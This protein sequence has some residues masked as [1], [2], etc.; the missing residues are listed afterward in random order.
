MVQKSLHG[1]P[2]AGKL[3][4]NS[5]CY[6]RLPCRKLKGLAI[7]EVEDLRAAG[8]DLPQMLFYTQRPQPAAQNAPG[9]QTA[10]AV[11]ARIKIQAFAPKTTQQR[12]NAR[13]SLQHGNIV[14]LTRQQQGGSQAGN[15]AACDHAAHQPSLKAILALLPPKPAALFSTTRGGCSSLRTSTGIPAVS[16]SGSS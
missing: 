7:G 8:R 9:M 10:A 11:K 14:P 13:A 6:R 15:A 5:F 3:Q 16:S 2:C 12:G 1:W 4:L